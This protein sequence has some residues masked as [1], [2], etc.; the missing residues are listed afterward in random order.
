MALL[1]VAMANSKDVEWYRLN[2]GLR[3]EGYLV[4][5]ITVEEVLQS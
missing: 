2:R 3:N 5:D 1:H 4:G